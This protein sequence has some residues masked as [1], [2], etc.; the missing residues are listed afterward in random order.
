[1]LL[2]DGKGVAA[3]FG[4]SWFSNLTYTADRDETLTLRVL[5]QAKHKV[6]YD[7]FTLTGE[8]T[9]AAAAPAKS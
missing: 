8:K 2:R 5:G 7:L 1:M 6:D 9:V 3:A 4:S